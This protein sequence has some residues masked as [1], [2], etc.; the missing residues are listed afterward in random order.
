MEDLCK[1]ILDPK[2]YEEHSRLFAICA[3]RDIGD[4]QTLGSLREVFS[5]EDTFGEFSA[6][7]YEAFEENVEAMESRSEDENL[8]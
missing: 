4:P 8:F 1:I 2:H 5:D 6:Y 7:A 3:L